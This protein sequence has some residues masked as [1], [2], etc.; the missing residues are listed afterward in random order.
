M[1]KVASHP[2]DSI[3]DYCHNIWQGS[4]EKGPTDVL[5]VNTSKNITKTKQESLPLKSPQ[6]M[7]VICLSDTH[8]RHHNINVPLGDIVVITGD[9]LT[10]NRHFSIDFSTDKLKNI[11]K[12][13]KELPHQ[14]KVF[15]G[16]NHD[17]V[18]EK[19]GASAIREIFEGCVYLEDEEI[20]L[21]G[22]K[23]WGTPYNRGSSDNS[24]F[25]SM[26]EE[27]LE[28]I[29]ENV[30]LLLTHGPVRSGVILGLKPRVHVW[31]HIHNY[32]GVEEVGE[33]LSVNASSVDGKYTQSH[34]PI[35]V[36]INLK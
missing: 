14:H 13:M 4:G 21:N 32:Y 5:Y 34:A 18:L 29:P 16:G 19:I 11:A 2:I 15:I 6:N 12:W 36:D 1:G 10:I 31:G 33:T 27:R 20:S 9:I 17:Y 7:K 26:P 22:L 25:Q 28:K 35:V 30:D 23:I 24:A 3:T 8:E